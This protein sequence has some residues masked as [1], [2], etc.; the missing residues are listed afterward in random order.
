MRKLKW[1]PFI[2]LLPQIK[3]MYNISNQIVWKINDCAYYN[4]SL[5]KLLHIK[6]G[7]IFVSFARLYTFNRKI[8][9]WTQTVATHIDIQLYIGYLGSGEGKTLGRRTEAILASVVVEWENCGSTRPPFH[10]CQNSQH[11]RYNVQSLKAMSCNL[12]WVP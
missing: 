10:S 4:N 1:G 5:W 6:Y 11:C 2:I 12:L 9:Q 7:S 3:G 8:T